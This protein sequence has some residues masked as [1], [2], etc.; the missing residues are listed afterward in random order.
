MPV[1]SVIV[2]TRDRPAELERTLAALEFQRFTDFEVVVVGPAGCLDAPGLARFR[3][4]VVA[5]ECAEPNVAAA[6][7]IGIRAA[8][9]AILAFCDDDAAPEPSWLGALCEGFHAA[10]V[11]AVGGFVLGPSGVRW[12]WRAQG[13]DRCGEAVELD[14]PEGGQPVVPE[15]P[16]G[17]TVTTIGTNMAWRRLALAEL[18]G[19]DE[20]YRFYLEETDADLR[21]VERGWRIA[22]AP[23]AVV[24]HAFA[25]SARRASNRAPLSLREV[26]ASKAVFLRRHAPAGMLDAALL[27]FRAA[28]RRRLLRFMVA[29][30]TEP[31]RLA[32]LLAELEAGIAE[33]LARPDAP[34]ADMSARQTTGPGCFVREGPGR[35]IRLA[36]IAARSGRGEAEALAERA[37]RSGAEVTLVDIGLLP[38]PH[39]VRFDARGFWYHSGGALNWGLRGRPPWAMLQ[40]GEAIMAELERARPLRGFDSYLHPE[41]GPWISGG[42]AIGARLE[43]DRV[44]VVETLTCPCRE[45]D[46]I[47]GHAKSGDPAEARGAGQGVRGG[48]DVEAVEEFA[49]CS[50]VD[51]AAPGERLVKWRESREKEGNEGGVPCRRSWNSVLARD[52]IDPKGNSYAG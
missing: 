32:S 43:L 37:A 33:G 25:R 15:P 23:R 21:L 39:R 7:N 16:P 17:V 20:A 5:A 3:G 52:E 9:G 6:R 50:C 19:F 12:Q 45:F 11:G 31:P 22:L 30:L 24:H 1:V 38:R 40:R 49:A 26:G 18:G 44:Y 47:L 46:I 51:S 42:Q 29:G 10:D 8:A 34:P 36:I 27:A 2:L 41:T 4:R 48:T 28:Q 13:F 14:L 35:G